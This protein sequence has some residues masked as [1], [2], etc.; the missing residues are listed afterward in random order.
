MK[1]VAM[2]AGLIA[3]NRVPLP[4]DHSLMAR[5]RDAIREF[6]ALLADLRIVRDLASEQMF[7]LLYG[8][9]TGIARATEPA[10]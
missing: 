5:E 9:S 8:A 10:A 3:T 6:Y 7:S 2:L 1:G 4:A